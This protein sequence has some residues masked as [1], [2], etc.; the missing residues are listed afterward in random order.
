MTASV[1]PSRIIV[2]GIEEPFTIASLAILSYS[3]LSLCKISIVIVV[4]LGKTFLVSLIAIFAI[5]F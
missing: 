2:Q 3:T 4:S 5:A 1:E